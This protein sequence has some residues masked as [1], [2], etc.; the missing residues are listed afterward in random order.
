MSDSIPVSLF[1]G[2]FSESEVSCQ[3]ACYGNV[4][5]VSGGRFRQAN[6]GFHVGDDPFAVDW[7]RQRIKENMQARVLLSGHQTHG[8]NIYCQTDLLTDDLEVADCDGFITDQPGVG[9]MIQQADCQ[10]V[11]CFDPARKL[12]GAVHSGW[13]GSVQNIVAKMINT[14]KEKFSSNP[15]DI[16]AIISPSLGPC[17]AEFVNYKKELPADFHKFMIGENHFDFWQISRAQLIAAG[18]I[19]ANIQSLDICTS[20]DENFFSYRRACREADGKTGR[21]CSLIML[22]D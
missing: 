3:W 16:M 6:I 22:E 15:V 18:L 17:C 5:G 20:C 1:S 14:M 21:H 2:G 12:V 13:R 10:A 19:D 11:L 7:N 4:G 9:L 8:A